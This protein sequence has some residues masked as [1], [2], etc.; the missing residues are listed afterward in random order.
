M[1]VTRKSVLM[2]CLS[3]MREELRL[4]STNYNGLEPKKGM[5]EAWRLGRE[6]IEILKDLIHAYDSEPVRKSLANWQK[7][8][9]AQ[10]E[11]EGKMD[12]DW[13]NGIDYLTPEQIEQIK[14]G[15]LDI[16]DVTGN[17]GPLPGGGEQI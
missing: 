6:K 5:E 10:Q 1:E 13:L 9:M 12:G 17:N 15:E 11:P 8:I 2:E 7:E 4:C 14:R 3:I 16:E